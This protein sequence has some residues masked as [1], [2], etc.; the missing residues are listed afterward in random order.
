MGVHICNVGLFLISFNLSLL[1]RVTSTMPMLMAY[2]LADSSHQVCIFIYVR[3]S[4]SRYKTVPIVQS[5]T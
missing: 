1:I 2:Y 3:G 4:D 5:K